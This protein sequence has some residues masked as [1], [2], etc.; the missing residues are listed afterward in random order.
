[1]PWPWHVL[2][3]Q[4]QDAHYGYPA[5]GMP[6]WN[7]GG[8]RRHVPWE[9]PFTEYD[10][11][12]G[13]WWKGDRKLRHFKPKKFW[14][15]PIDGKR[16]GALGRLKDALTGEGADVFVTLSGD[17]R[18]L[19]RDVPQRWQWT[20]AGL[21]DWERWEKRMFDKDHRRQDEMPIWNTTA[22]AEKREAKPFYNFRTREFERPNYQWANPDH[23]WK[24]AQWPFGAKHSSDSPLSKQDVHNN[25]QTRV[26]PW[27][28]F[29]PGGRPG[30]RGP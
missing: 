19:M 30:R 5:L 15:R 24:D 14:T 28:G 6:L 18:T 3:E 12:H 21:S 29:F 2:A 4:T 10:P 1:M 25:W 26:P 9:L 22:A 8:D 13:G 17:K 7:V 27:A 20:N 11:I 23:F 16:P